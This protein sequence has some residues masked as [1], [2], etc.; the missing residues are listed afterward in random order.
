MTQYGQRPAKAQA[1]P[2]VYTVLLFVGILALLVAIGLGYRRLTADAQSGQG[3]GMTA[4][5]IFQGPKEAPSS[6]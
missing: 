4:G 2:N 5:E 3:Y 1:A 6:R